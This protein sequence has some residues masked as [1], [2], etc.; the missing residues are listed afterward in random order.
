MLPSPLALS[1]GTGSSMAQL[2]RHQA[3]AQGR[4]RAWSQGRER[5]GAWWSL[6]AAGM[7]LSAGARGGRQDEPAWRVPC[8]PS[9]PGLLTG[10]LGSPGRAPALADKRL[11]PGQDTGTPGG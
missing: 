6:R 10:C 9:W 1:G 4:S 5:G 8:S 2:Q 7:A 3:H 11:G